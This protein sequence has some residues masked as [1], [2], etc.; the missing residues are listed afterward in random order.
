MNTIAD[1]AIAPNKVQKVLTIGDIIE[2]PDNNLSYIQP[3]HLPTFNQHN[4]SQ[5]KL[6]IKQYDY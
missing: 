1:V 2:A 4:D 3:I 6:G 5:C